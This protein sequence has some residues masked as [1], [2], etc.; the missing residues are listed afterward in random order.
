MRIRHLLTLLS[1][2]FILL[3][4]CS[5]APTVTV[6]VMETEAVVE[7]H[8]GEE[9]EV[10]SPADTLENE[11]TRVLVL[12]L[13][14]SG[15]TKDS[16]SEP[17]QA[18]AGEVDDGGEMQE[19]AKTNVADVISVGVSGN[20]GAY[21][22]SVGIRSPETGCDQY[23]DWWEVITDDGVLIYRRVLLHSHVNEQPFV[24]SGGPANI[25]QDT[26]VI[27]RAHM[28]TGG[29][30]GAAFQGSVQSGFNEIE[31]DPIFAADLSETPPLP[32]GCAF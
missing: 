5:S 8:P 6:E 30:G 24:R 3:S 14:A 4:A 9:D 21:Q 27:V 1:L 16:S 26:V 2:L 29:Y 22:F 10:S 31:L 19:P 32:D 12:P 23:A 7:A 18:P 28:N 25:T 17:T 13:V 15:D 20:D 11:E